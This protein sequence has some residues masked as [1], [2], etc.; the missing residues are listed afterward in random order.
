MGDRI[1]GVTR[2][3]ATL[4]DRFNETS[5]SDAPFRCAALRLGDGTS[6]L[7]S[8]YCVDRRGRP[9]AAVESVVVQLDKGETLGDGNIAE[10]REHM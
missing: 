7:Y 8:L 10:F 6:R 5:G 2:A 1:I 9:V 3:V 4:R